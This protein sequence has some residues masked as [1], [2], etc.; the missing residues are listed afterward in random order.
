MFGLDRPFV[1]S[2]QIC[3]CEMSFRFFW[4]GGLCDVGSPVALDHLLEKAKKGI[5]TVWNPSVAASLKSA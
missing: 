4:V 1:P 5:V 2:A 3:S